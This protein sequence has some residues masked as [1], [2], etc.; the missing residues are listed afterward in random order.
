[1]APAPK[2]MHRNSCTRKSGC[3]CPW[4]AEVYDPRA[5]T[6]SGKRGAKKRKRFSGKGAHA[7]AKG[8]QRDTEVALTK[9]GTT[10][11]SRT[12]TLSAA[13]EDWLDKAE[14]GEIRSRK[15]TE[16]KPS[17]LRGYRRSL[18]TYVLDDLG[19]RRLHEIT[20]R[21]LQSL[22]Q[23]LNGQG[24]AGSTVRNTVVPLQSLYHEHRRE[25]DVDPTIGLDLPEPGGRRERAA[26]PKEAG[27]LLAAL[28][29]EDRAL[30]AT[31]FYAGPR[32]G[33]LRAL[34]AANVD[35]EHSI[36][37]EHGWDVRE[38][39]ILPK[40]KA[41]IRLIPVPELLRVELVAHLERTGRSGDAFLFGRTNGAPFT[42]S[43]MRKRARTA[44][45]WTCECGHVASEHDD[46]K[47]NECG[48][49]EFAALE[50]I[51]FH[52]ARH[53]YSSYLDAAGIS[54]TRA[55][56]Y[57]GHSSSSMRARYTHQLEAQ[58]AEDAQR[59]N[60]YLVGA[61]AGKVVPIN[62]RRSA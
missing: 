30:W 20:G 18:E 19:A 60:E 2:Q 48:C 21:D 4:E 45:A 53:S 58:L 46:E 9:R 42:D 44:W 36:S 33:E 39:E 15:R 7:E 27:K 10:A 54:E 3:S 8:W 37:I 29:V 50:P 35:P 16:F 34:R 57:M 22:V 41:G 5:V 55:D 38:G 62:E 23:R 13:W 11:T 6:K 52:E 1:M 59:L 61:A 17:T 32:L 56:R 28:P 26:S 12:P 40:S 14:R 51:G 47:C 25:L 49:V 43:H 24:L 31:A